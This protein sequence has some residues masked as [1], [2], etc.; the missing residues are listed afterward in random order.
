MQWHRRE[1][2]AEE[3]RHMCMW[4]P[5]RHPRCAT[6]TWDVPW[7]GRE[8]PGHRACQRHPAAMSC[9]GA[10]HRNG[11][12][13]P[14]PLACSQPPPSPKRGK[15]SKAP[16]IAHATPQ[17]R[18]HTEA[19]GQSGRCH[20]VPALGD[21]TATAPAPPAPAPGAQL[22][23]RL[24]QAEILRQLPKR[25]HGSR[26]CPCVPLHTR[27]CY[28][29]AV[30]AVPCAPPALGTGKEWGQRDPA[31][32]R[33]SSATTSY[34]DGPQRAPASP[35][36]WRVLSPVSLSQAMVTAQDSQRLHM[37]FM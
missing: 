17:P 36:I 9:A 16:R 25:G 13:L 22:R 20:P 19:P 32:G 6:D 1:H 26:R 24:P 35:Q 23:P 11:V 30:P 15:Q 34:L 21:T 8:M 5:I 4:S 27:A 10:P 14:E 18:A 3:G 29:P 37:Y 31:Q 2:Q 7:A 12:M 33:R 28:T